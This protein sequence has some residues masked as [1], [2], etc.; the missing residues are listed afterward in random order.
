MLAKCRELKP[1]TVKQ[2]ELSSDFMLFS[3]VLSR[4]Y[5]CRDVYD[6]MKAEIRLMKEEL[7]AIERYRT[8]KERSLAQCT[9]SLEAMRATKE[10]LESEL[11]QEL[12]AQLSVTDQRQVSKKKVI[13]N[14]NRLLKKIVN[15]R[16]IH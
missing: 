10:G 3:D 14:Y 16:W 6:K 7:S 12:M 8:P 15:F 1:K 11:H 9:S 4:T 13:E 5:C 2:S